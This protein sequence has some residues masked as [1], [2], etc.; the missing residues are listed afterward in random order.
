[1]KVKSESKKPF[2]RFGEFELLKAIAIIG[3]PAVHLMEESLEGGYASAGLTSFGTMIIGL[4]AFGPS[5][6]MMCMGF[7][8]GGGKTSAE[9]IR[10]NGIQFLLIGAILNIVRWLIPGIIQMLTINTNLIEDLKFCLQ[11]DIYYFV[12]LYF[13]FY[14]FLKKRNITPSGMIFISVLLLTVNTLLT[15]ITGKYITNPVVSSLVGN[16]VYVDSNSC[17]PLLSWAIFPS[18]GILLGDI[19]KKSDEDRREFIMRRVLDFS[20]VLFASFT[21]FLL[22]YKIDFM[23]VLVSPSNNYITDLPNVILL[24][25]LALFLISLTY[26]LCKRIG[27][28]SFMKFMLRISTFIIPFYLLQ[29]IIIAWIFYILPILHVSQGSFTTGWYLLSVFVVTAICIFVSTRY[30]M[31]IMKFL[32]KITT[33]KKKRKKKSNKLQ[34]SE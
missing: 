1:M 13:I 18:I 9:G 26:Y 14:S 8:I 3:L 6:F 5:V 28:S 16:I 27:A 19:L 32:L 12:G 17:F 24:V 30:G 7:G 15:P 25:S 4:C 33:I 2:I 11:S 31:K 21:V 29:W 20:F 10:K 22:V 23:K 34:V